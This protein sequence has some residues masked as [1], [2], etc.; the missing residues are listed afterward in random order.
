MATNNTQTK[1]YQYKRKTL[2]LPNGERKE[3]YAK[4]QEELDDKVMEVRIL[5]HSGVDV[6]SEETF[7]HFAQMWYDV[8]KKPYLR[9]KS[10]EMVK[11]ILNQ[12]ILPVIGG[13]RLQDITPM[14]IQAIM[15]GL[16]GKSNSLQSKVLINLR[17]IF[18]AAQENGLIVRS[19]VSSM[20]KPGGKKTQEKTA[21]TPQEC[22]KL[23]ERVRNPRAKTFLLI[24]LNTGMRRGEILALKWD[25][26]DFEKKLI[27][28]RRNAVLM[29]GGTKLSD[30]LKTKAGRRD[31]PLT[32]TLEAHLLAEKKRTH[33][34]YIL[35]MQN[36]QPMTVSS[37]KSMWRLIERELPERHVTAHILRHTYITRLFEA[38][39]DIKEIQYLAG[40]SSV[41]MTLRVYTHYD[42]A[43]R[44]QTT[45]EKVR[46]AM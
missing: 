28:V 2:Q 41:D 40:H 37:Y 36:H 30:E 16:V 4:T 39:L 34:Q 26:V 10:Q 43:S 35:A 1:K 27:H 6:C 33:S 38:G 25:D 8:Y 44:E 7:G 31:I 21:L 19:P 3:V 22:E 5:T 42:R 18:K 45:I 15:S 13:Y 29:R 32:E 14:Q 17:S 12:H 24:A 20:L 46:A 9:D 23:I 11:Y